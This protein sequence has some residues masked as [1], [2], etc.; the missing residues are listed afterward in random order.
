MTT[1][2]RQLP[3]A[4]T[5][6]RV[7]AIPALAWAALTGSSATFAVLVLGSLAGDIAD[8]MLARALRATTPLGAQLDSIADTLLFFITIVGALVFFPDDVR[9]HPVAF[10]SAPAAWLIESVVAL[11][12]YGRLSSFHTYLS[13]VAAVAMGTFIAVLFLYGM[14]PVLLHVAAALVLLATMEELLLLWMLPVWTPDVR[15]LYWVVRS[16]RST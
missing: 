9:A 11:V 5:I 7:A 3:N 15:G 16:R 12:R 8:G 14:L 10:S 13:R 6:L 2:L 1:S 4:I